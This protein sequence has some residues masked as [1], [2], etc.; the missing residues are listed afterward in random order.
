M[1][2]LS[3]LISSSYGPAEGSKVKLKVR[4]LDELTEQ[5]SMIKRQN[6]RSLVRDEENI[7]YN[8]DEQLLDAVTDRQTAVQANAIRCRDG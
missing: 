4:S 6:A 1:D 3:T 5:S 2:L 7:R 8:R